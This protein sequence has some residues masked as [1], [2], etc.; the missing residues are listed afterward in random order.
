MLD[1]S[2]IK[3]LPDFKLTIPPTYDEMEIL[4]PKTIEVGITGKDGRYYKFEIQTINGTSRIKL[5]PM[6]EVTTATLDLND[7][8]YLEFYLT[9]IV[10]QFIERYEDKPLRMLLKSIKRQIETTVITNHFD[11]LE[12]SKTLLKRIND[13]ILDQET[14]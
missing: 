3:Q 10:S 1:P 5:N 7:K 9:Y 2:K 11:Y 8:E 4:T 13:A 6:F 12:F 14:K